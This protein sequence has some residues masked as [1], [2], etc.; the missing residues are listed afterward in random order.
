[1]TEHMYRTESI[2]KG[3]NVELGLKDSR[4][5]Q[6]SFSDIYISTDPLDPV[7]ALN[8]SGEGITP[9]SKTRSPTRLPDSFH[10]DCRNLLT[11]VEKTWAAERFLPEFSIEYDGINYRCSQIGAPD[12]TAIEPRASAL[13]NNKRNWCL[14]RI[15]L[16]HMSLSSLGMPSWC[17]EEISMLGGASGLLL[18]AGG[19]GSG[20]STTSAA[21]LKNWVD[22]HG[23]VGVTIEDPPEKML[24]GFHEG[25]Q[26]YQ[27]AVR[28]HGFANAIRASRR[29]A[30]RYMFLGEVR[31]QGGAEELLQISLGGPTVLTTIHAS[32]AVE[33]LM[34]LSKF[35]AGSRDPAA[36]N[37]RIAAC[38]LGVLWQSLNNGKLEVQY[39]SF[40]GRNASAMRTKI[41]EGRFRLLR[42]DM[43]YQ[44]NLRRL[45]RF[46]ESF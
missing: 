2:E 28:D 13:S 40:R 15:D 7:L 23:G 26:I 34:A 5:N 18:V 4:L 45:G 27:I 9:E 20:K 16:T 14:R 43:E 42:E 35:A 32:G 10:S 1:M 17:S 6:I 46:S 22:M 44:S 25:G 31:D 12:S 33:A 29:W 37:D 24:A 30:Y 39:L 38:I 8:A 11:I 3:L 41:G 36:V 19:F 21:C